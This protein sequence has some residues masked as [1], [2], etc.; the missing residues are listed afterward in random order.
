MLLVQQFL[1][2][3][4]IGALI[5]E[6]GVYTSF[7]KCGMKFSLSY[8]QIEAK[9]SDPLSQECRG[10]ILSSIDGKRFSGIQMTNGRIN[11]EDII[12]GNTK[13]IAFPFK[14]FFNAGQGSQATINWN[15]PKLSVLDKVDGSLIILYFDP[16]QSVWHTA[17][18]GTPEADVPLD[19]NPT[20]TFRTLFEKALRDTTGLSFEEFTKNLD[21]SITYCF[22]VVSPLNRIV[23]A[24]NE[25]KIFLLAAR[26]ISLPDYPELDID[27]LDLDVPRVQSYKLN[28]LNEIMD[29]VSTLNPL[30]HEGVVVRDSNFNRIKVKNAAYLAYSKCRDS[31]GTSDR[32]CLELVLL[33]KDDDAIPFLPQEIV[34][35][36]NR[37]KSGV[38]RLIQ[39]HDDYY[40]EILDNNPSDRKSFA[41]LVNQ[42]PN[43]WAA[44]FFAIYGNKSENMKDFIMKSKKNGTWA[45]SFL[46]KILDVINKFN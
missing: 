25:Y 10:L 46:D 14:R 12:P 27:T 4:S 42:N 44:P 19:G 15:D 31:L 30:E 1:K 5:K 40:L 29:W 2:N 9:E 20:Y 36:L 11:R 37:I 13:I 23:C 22:E 3:K 7:S 41:V 38:Q 16:F 35:N 32:N 43:I 39:E 26:N 45:D 24:Y 17:T 18:R 34:D 8:D 6:H 28:N 33:E 21:K